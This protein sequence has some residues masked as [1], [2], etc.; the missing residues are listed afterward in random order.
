MLVLYKFCFI[1]KVILFILKSHSHLY[2]KLYGSSLLARNQINNFF[3]QRCD[4]ITNKTIYIQNSELSLKFDDT[5]N[6]FHQTLDLYKKE[7]SSEINTPEKYSII[8]VEKESNQPTKDN[9]LNQKSI[10]QK[11]LDLHGFREIGASLFIRR[12]YLISNPKNFLPI[13]W[14]I[15]KE[16]NTQKEKRPLLNILT[17][18]SNEFHIKLKSI[19]N[20]NEQ[21]RA[22]IK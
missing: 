11:F 2:M 12:I 15:G 5:F 1:Q 18:I 9:R 10:Y 20:N 13:N 22:E 3:D 7:S 14:Y 6:L 4:D 19:D 21:Y 8:S 17:T 16:N